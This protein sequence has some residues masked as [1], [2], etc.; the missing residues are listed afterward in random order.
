MNLIDLL[1]STGGLLPKVLLLLD[2][3]Q[4]DTL[5]VV[6]I[7]GVLSRSAS[8]LPDHTLRILLVHS[9][10]TIQILRV[11]ALNV[12]GIMAVTCLIIKF[13]ACSALDHLSIRL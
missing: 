13:I 11:I 5:V 2:Q 12:E 4:V 6:V 1:L 10:V 8:R 7:V 3:H 9:N